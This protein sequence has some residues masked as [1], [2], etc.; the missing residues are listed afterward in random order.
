MLRIVTL[1]LLITAPFAH[2]RIISTPHEK[3]IVALENSDLAKRV[4][5]Y[6]DQAYSLGAMISVGKHYLLCKEANAFETN[7]A[8][9]WVPLNDDSA[10]PQPQ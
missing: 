5:Y 4:C 7:G 8:L 9:K 1:L 2:A 6:Q 10:T 3:P